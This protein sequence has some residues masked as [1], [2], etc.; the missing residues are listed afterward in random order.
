[1]TAMAGLIRSGNANRPRAAG[2]FTYVGL[3]ILVAIIA[4]V[5]AA[6]IR[7][8][9]ALQRAQAERDLLHIGEQFSDALKSY[10]AATPAGQPQQPPTLKDLLKDPRFPGIRRHLRK[11]FIDPVTGRAEWGVIYL[12]DNKGVLGIHSLSPARPVK[13]GNFPARFLAFD[14]KEKISEWV[15][16]WNGQAPTPA[17]QLLKPGQLGAGASTPGAVPST[18]PVPPPA[19]TPGTPMTGK[20]ASPVA[21]P[22]EKPEPAETPE[23]AEPVPPPEPAGPVD[24]AEP[25]EPA[26]P[27]NQ[28]APAEP[29]APA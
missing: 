12:A 8:G 17:A 27:S 20:P 2:G 29:G 19:P 5:A 11:I 9:A 4:L 18:S 21:E 13:V 3:I 26:E 22:V 6:T 23:P 10:A 28:A 16:T 25:A 14:G 15:F 7:V 1:M 24:P